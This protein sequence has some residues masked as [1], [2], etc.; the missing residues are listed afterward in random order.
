MYHFVEKILVRNKGNRKVEHNQPATREL[1]PGDIMLSAIKDG[2][3][4]STVIF[5]EGTCVDLGTCND[6]N[7]YINS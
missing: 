6:L 1:Y 7:N 2:L 3:K 4:A 5:R